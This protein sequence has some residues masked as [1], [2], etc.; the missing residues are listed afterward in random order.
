VDCTTV[1]EMSGSFKLTNPQ[2][3]RIQRLRGANLVIHGTAGTADSEG[4]LRE[5]PARDVVIEDCVFDKGLGRG[6]SIASVN[7]IQIS[8]DVDGVQIERCILNA[9]GQNGHAIQ[10]SHNVHGR[11]VDCL[12][13]GFN[14]VSGPDPAHAI[15]LVGGSTVNDDFERVSRFVDQTRIRSDRNP[16]PR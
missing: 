12:I 14:G 7:C 2:R 13:R 8:Q 1:G 10:L 15:D 4:K 6:A 9:A 5:E 16:V 3:V 11:V